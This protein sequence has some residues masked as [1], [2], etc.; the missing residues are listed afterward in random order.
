M[1]KNGET[2]LHGAKNAGGLHQ[3]AFWN[4]AETAKLLIEFG[5]AV[6]AK[7]NDGNTPLHSAA[8]KG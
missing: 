1:R 3:A 2:P 6:N 7:D 8:A 5:A 4:A